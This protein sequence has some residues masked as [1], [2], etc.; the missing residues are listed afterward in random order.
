V[1]FVSFSEYEF[2]FIA[3]GGAPTG[4]I[5]IGGFPVGLVAIGI[6]PLG[7]VSL[8]CGAGLGL[9]NITCGIGAGTWVRACGIAI[10]SDAEAVG[11]PLSLGG[12]ADSQWRLP[13]LILVSLLVLYALV[14]FGGERYAVTKMNRV[15]DVT[16]DAKMVQAEGL[17]I[18][19]D[20]PCLLHASLRS[21]GHERLH[22]SLQVRC[23]SLTIFNRYLSDRCDVEQFGD[24]NKHSYKLR[25][26]IGYRAATS[27]EDS[28]T[29]EQPG[30]QVDTIRTEGTLRTYTNGATPTN[31]RMQIESKS[32]EVSGRG[33]LT[34]KKREI[35]SPDRD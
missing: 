1:R 33:L 30:L 34:N 8:A 18:E 28:H 4:I 14:T 10:G 19:P 7:V 12:Q 16:W 24:G 2:G 26:N 22:S 31:I 25:C 6:I 15:V 27:D 29:P 21:D 35:R 17:Y 23:G 32:R 9:V 13:S 11:L 5:A 20:T 3:I